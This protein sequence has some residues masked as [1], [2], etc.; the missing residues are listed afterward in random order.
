MRLLSVNMWPMNVFH[1]ILEK[2]TPARFFQIKWSLLSFRGMTS[3]R[4]FEYF[5]RTYLIRYDV[6]KGYRAGISEGVKLLTF[7][8]ST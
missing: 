2:K 7:R 3:S 6:R 8:G 4:I 1:E 5:G